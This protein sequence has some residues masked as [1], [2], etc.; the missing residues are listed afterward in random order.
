M[1]LDITT[2][3]QQ[4]QS[5]KKDERKIKRILFIVYAFLFWLFLLFLLIMYLFIG[6]RT[7]FGEFI[8]IWPPLLWIFGL[9]P[10]G[11]ICLLFGHRYHCLFAMIGIILFL[12][13][14]EEWHSLLRFSTD[15]ANPVYSTPQPNQ[16]S[17]GKIPLRIIVWNIDNT[18]SKKVLSIL[19]TYKPDICF[20]QEIPK[21][22]LSASDTT[23]YWKGYTWVG[24]GDCGTL[25]R[26]SIHKIDTLPVGP[27]SPPQ[28]LSMDL[29]D[30]RQVLLVNVR[31]MLPTLLFD[32]FN[33]QE[34]KQ[35]IE[36]HDTRINQ[37]QLLSRLITKTG[38]SR[39][40]LAGD[41]NVAARSVSLFPLR[42]ILRDAWLECGH[43]WGRTMTI[44]FPVSRIDQCWISH[45]IT[46]VYGRVIPEPI[47]DHR[48]V[49]IDLAI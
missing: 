44:D 24:N 28:M 12:L 2:V 48:L 42:R 23:G 26:Y 32:I 14:T 36:T 5:N 39:V 7:S 11:L 19:E 43:G 9:I 30:H 46:C 41:F 37:Y 20:L 21:L 38:Q 45:P 15:R 13:L 3:E 18:G 17:S 16:L 10:L 47:S 31:I 35:F 40:I 34:R 6:D 22:G 8:T 27:W 33:S 25:S 1:T 4:P 49:L 29:P